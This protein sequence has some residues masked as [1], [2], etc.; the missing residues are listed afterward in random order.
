MKEKILLVVFIVA[1][2]IAGCIRSQPPPADILSDDS[3]QTSPADVDIAPLK[4]TSTV[5]NIP[6]PTAFPTLSPEQAQAT[7]LKWLENNG[8]CRLPCI[9]GLESVR[10]TTE[11]RRELLASFGQVQGE[12]FI[13][14]LRSE[15]KAPGALGYAY[16]SDSSHHLFVHLD[17]YEEN[18][19]IKYLSLFTDSAKDNIRIFDDADYKK[20]TRYYSLSQILTNYGAPSDI[21]LATWPYDPFTKSDYEP[22]II[23]LI[24][25]ELGFRVEY[26]FEANKLND[27]ITGCPANSVLTITTWQPNADISLQEIASIGIG[28][29]FNKSSYKYFK[30]IGEVTT[31]D[32]DKFYDTFINQGEETCITTPA[33]FWY[34]GLP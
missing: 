3:F 20:L 15:D 18:G 4:A 8:N 12:K 19:R 30:P 29:E 25:S 26:V 14:S 17:F 7:I 11:R 32:I 33:E 34:S 31:M 5:T 2:S 27:K 13:I 6:S 9:W 23:V 10:T 24:Y 28:Y 1:V 16:Q 22:F 21:Y